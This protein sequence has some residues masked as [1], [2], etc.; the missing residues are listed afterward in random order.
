MAGQVSFFTLLFGWAVIVPLWVKERAPQINAWVL[1]LLICAGFIAS[2]V[3]AYLA[4]KLI[5]GMTTHVENIAVEFSRDAMRFGDMFSIATA[6]VR[7]A[8]VHRNESSCMYVALYLQNGG[9]VRIDPWVAKD[10]DLKVQ[11]ARYCELC[12]QIRAYFSLH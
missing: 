3:L 4:F 1:V 11:R 8:R 10:P 9:Q 5:G 7:K 2:G 6:E 12:E